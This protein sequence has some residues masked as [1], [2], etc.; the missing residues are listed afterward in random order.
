MIELKGVLPSDAEWPSVECLYTE[1]FPVAERRPLE[2]FR[3][4]AEVGVLHVEAVVGNGIFC[5]FVTWWD[6]D[7]FIFGEHFA[8]LPE[9]RG[10]GIGTQVLDLLLARSQ[11][12][13]VLEA[14]LPTDDMS[15]RRIGFYERNGFVTCPHP[16]IQPAYTPEGGEIR[17]QLMSRGMTL[18]PAAE[19]ERVR[20]RIYSTVYGVKIP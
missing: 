16:Y 8:V 11:R 13:M 17:L 18:A 5:G 6:M 4:L 2:A 1:A 12:P 9:C 20:D 3:N 14:E 19:F 10:G 15:V 7:Y